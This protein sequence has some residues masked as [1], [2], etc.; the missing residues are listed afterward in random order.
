MAS[1]LPDVRQLGQANVSPNK[2]VA[3][4]DAG[5][6]ATGEV[7]IGRAVS[8]VGQMLGRAIATE[9][10][11]AGQA[12][13]K[14]GAELAQAGQ[15]GA[16][17][18]ARAI[19]AGGEAQG[20]ATAQGGTALG[21]ATQEGGTAIGRATEEGGVAIGR[22]TQTGGAALARGV[23][24]FGEGV[25]KLGTGA[26]DLQLANDQLD[27]HRA[28]AT[29]QARKTFLDG[30][31]DT[32][33]EGF[34]TMPG[35]YA[36]ALGK[37]RDESAAEIASPFMRNRFMTDVTNV[38]AQGEVMATRKARAGLAEETVGKATQQLD[39]LRQAALVDKD[40]VQSA[41]SIAIG[42]DVINSLKDAGYVT[43]TQAQTMRTK[44]SQGFA[45][46][47]VAS[48]PAE[49]QVNML[50]E[51]PKNREGVLDR[52]KGNE[53]VAGNT[54]ATNPNSSA[55]GD[56]QFTNKTWLSTLQAHRPDLLTGK[57]EAEAL[58][59]RADSK[60][61]REM[62]GYLLD[63]NTAGLQQAGIV[64]TPG[65]Q[66][67][68]HFLGLPQA[69][70]VAKAAPGTPVAD[71]LTDKA[72][73]SNPSVLSGK[74]VDTVMAWA[75]QK[76][77]GTVR[78]SGSMIDFVPE[79]RR[80]A[81]LNTAET[82]VLRRHQEDQ[83]SLAKENYDLR[84]LLSSDITST[85]K[86]G[87][88]VPDLDFD[89]I[90]TVLG[91][92]AVQEWRD[93]SEDAHAFWV[94]THD[95]GAM[96]PAQIST[97]LTSIA[98]TPGAPDFERRQKVYDEV[99]KRVDAVLKLRV[100]DPAMAVADVP[101]V[102]AAAAAVNPKDPAT[103]KA[104]VDARLAAQESA[105]IASPA[106]VPI[107][108]ARSYLTPLQQAATLDEAAPPKKGEPSRIVQAQ[109]EM[110]TKLKQ[111]YGEH[112]D[113]VMIEVLRQ[114][115]GRNSEQAEAAGQVMSSLLTGQLPGSRPARQMQVA[116][117][118]D[119]AAKAMEGGPLSTKHVGLTEMFGSALSA[120]A[121]YMGEGSAM[122]EQVGSSS[123]ALP[124]KPERPKL[125]SHKDI[126]TLL[127]TPDA[128]IAKRSAQ[129]DKHYG[130]GSAEKILSARKA[131]DA[132]TLPLAK[133]ETP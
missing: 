104:L 78:G 107:A 16:G 18:L 6:I 103:V 21:K 77:G 132:G 36:D 39:A 50:R 80:V 40:P 12:E 2:R 43:E 53:G 11:S 61:S 67:L 79:D 62:A 37:I 51:A 4:L 117:E 119:A 49:V 58:K 112:A 48:L 76:M 82:T 73:S 133:D 27:F 93:H 74:T 1:K 106:P 95:L 131:P 55:M 84:G 34:K 129:F 99:S 118:T 59:L 97:R 114:T 8:E 122:P 47:V 100:E 33:K 88:G 46:A 90:R 57:T 108:E 128:D 44:W 124:A 68:A 13:A 35:R 69:V 38:S 41:R 91:A 102:R 25:T 127:G 32:D 60:L 31:L 10:T 9:G 109:R 71:I 19:G 111:T 7:A 65:M 14:G 52:I 113:K 56:F 29:F 96:T 45:E 20:R 98:P 66:Y 3:S 15:A 70:A 116:A 130:P 115:T 125:P 23:E 63:D 30:S 101:T 92:K 24:T 83:A 87:Q 110:I 105:G 22:A 5:P 26:L 86:T 64:P 94:N 126:Q 81:L 75:G 123:P 54:A 28:M 72:I 85:L 121:S 42:S 17:A 120:G 89:R